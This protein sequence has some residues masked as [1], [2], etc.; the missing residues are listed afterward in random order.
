M[1]PIEVALEQGARR[2]V[3]FKD[4]LKLGNWGKDKLYELIGQEKV[5]AVKDGHATLIVLESI[6]DYQRSLPRLVA[7]PRK[8]R[9]RR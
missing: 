9:R 6:Y 2:L 1:Q 4:A 3:S 7:R 5:I 8:K